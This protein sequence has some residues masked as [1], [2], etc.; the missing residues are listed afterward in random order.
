M[1]YYGQIGSPSG[2]TVR[3]VEVETSNGI[4]AAFRRA[5]ELCEPGEVCR[6]VVPI[7]GTEHMDRGVV[8]DE[9]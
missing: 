5:S 9:S 3:E 7:E 2:M 4:R 6:G 1:R 8:G